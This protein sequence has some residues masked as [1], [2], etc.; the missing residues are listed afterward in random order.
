MP[1]IE[2]NL[3]E[4]VKIHDWTQ[5][6]EEWSLPWGRTE[7]LWWGTLFPRIHAFVPTDTI[8]EI[9]PGFG[10][11]THYLKDLCTN[12]TV[13][14]MAEPCIE[15]CKQRF[16]SCSRITYHIN[17]GKSLDMIPDQSVDFVF[18]FDS[19][20][21]AESDVIEAYLSQLPRKLKP[22]GVGFI[23]HSNSGVYIPPIKKSLP[24]L[25]KGYA[26]KL[27]RHW[28]AESMTAGLFE[29]YCEQA[30]LQCIAQEITNWITK[31]L[32]LPIDCFSLFTRKDS[33]W[34]RPNKV[35][36]NMNFRHEALYLGKLAR[37]Y[38]TSSLRTL[39]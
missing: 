24:P 15:A 35:Y 13:V 10:R 38:S 19:L 34:T 21:H 16:S 5:Q 39:N 28:R 12:L 6:G 11:I 33:V 18:S 27:S 20:V 2:E 29:K 37:L 7:F 25:L 36:W 14:D 3:Q 1:T 30:G 22:N 17:N 8:L 9:A 32:P 4:W 23:H 26:V 31:Y